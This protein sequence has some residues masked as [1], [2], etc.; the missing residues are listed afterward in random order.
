MMR[1][2]LRPA[3]VAFPLALAFALLGS[4]CGDDETVAAASII[5]F[6]ADPPGVMRG[7]STQLRWEV[8]GATRLRIFDD[9]GTDVVDLSEPPPTGSFPTAALQS[10]TRFTLEVEG[11]ADPLRSQANLTVAVDAPD[12]EFLEVVA[13]PSQIL[14]GQAA[15]IQWTT[16]NALAVDVETS[17]GAVVV[18]AGPPSGQTVVRPRGSATYTLTA[19]GVDVDATATVTVL[20][21]NRPPSI[22]RFSASPAVVIPGGQVS[23]TWQVIG[24]TQVSI[25]GVKTSTVVFEGPEEN[26]SRTV[27]LGESDDFVL[28]AE[29]PGGTRSSTI[30]VSVRAP[31]PVRI[32]RFLVEPNPAPRGLDPEV[33]WAVQGAT[34]IE[35]RQDGASIQQTGLRSG[36]IPTTVT[37]D[38]AAFVLTATGAAGSA[39]A[40]AEAFIHDPPLIRTFSVS[41]VAVESGGQVTVSWDVENVTQL[42]LF[43]G[44]APIPGFTALTATTGPQQNVSGSLVLT[45]TTTRLFTLEAASAAGSES[46][47]R[48][49][50]VGREEVEPNDT[51]Q[52]A[53]AP[54]APGTTADYLG[55]ANFPDT[56]IYL[57]D[58]PDG[59]SV[60][61][62]TSS[63]PGICQLDTVLTLRRNGVDIVTD[64]NGGVDA[65]SSISPEQYAGAGILPGGRYELVL[66]N[67]LVG[68]YLLTLGPGS[69]T[70]GNGSRETPETCDDGGRADNDGCSSACGL[71]ITGVPLTAPGGSL[72]F[73]TVAAGASGVAQLTIDTAGQSITATAADTADSCNTVDTSLELLDDAGRV[74]LSAAGGGPTGTAGNCGAFDRRL[75]R[76][77]RDLRVGTYYLRA[78]NEGPSSGPIRI[79]YAVLAP[80]C[81]NSFVESR[82]GEQCDDGNSQAGDGCSPQCQFEGGAA[83]EQEPNNDQATATASGLVGPGRIQLRGEIRPSGDDDVWAFEVPAQRTLFFSARTYTTRGQFTSCDRTITDTR[84]FLEQAGVEATAPSSGELAFNDD[85]DS[86]GNVWCSGLFSVPLSGGQN[87]TTYYIRIQG[88]RDIG[89]ASWF[90]DLR[91]DP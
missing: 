65:C 59:G 14:A 46:V 22:V 44:N 68:P 36:R 38:R 25:R 81:G 64:D 8:S 6:E 56:D 2:V 45:A 55:Q 33:A 78:N 19:R 29:G 1:I 69:Q 74:L 3:S 17:T 34:A 7:G 39:S 15:A 16:N 31:E 86:L 73:G 40:T 91:L 67:R 13:V 75:D 24:A 21:G 84:I 20:V 89:L 85:I 57:I 88:W 30:S 53:L 80:V 41:P 82:A 90:L 72:D 79:R 42:A 51:S 49:S 35:I 18:E 10:D 12:P 52:T 54:P 70:C 11:L 9:F 76:A 28:R 32:N 5:A 63:G 61:A 62:Q 47:R 27:S 37:A 26:G 83:P 60:S 66:Q 87:G 50:V 58:I 4:A 23:L 48:L 43:S 71:E 77:A